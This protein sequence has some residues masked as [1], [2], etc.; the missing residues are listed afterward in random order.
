MGQVDK[1]EIKAGD[2]VKVWEAREGVVVGRYGN[3]YY[4]VLF[5]TQL[6]SPIIRACREQDLTLVQHPL[7]SS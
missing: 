2:L 7:Q 1:P 5:K 3:G 4:E 6:G